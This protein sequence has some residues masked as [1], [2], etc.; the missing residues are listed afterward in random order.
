MSCRIFKGFIG[1]IAPS[2]TRAGKSKAMRA[3]LPNRSQFPGVVFPGAGS[4][5]HCLWEMSNCHKSFLTRII[6]K[7][8]RWNTALSGTALLRNSAKALRD[9]QV[10]LCSS[11]LFKWVPRLQMGWLLILE[12]LHCLPTW[13]DMDLGN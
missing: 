3:A 13:I 12:G 9:A 5:L 8:F 7:A 2:E 11:S 6:T 1:L 4:H 10:Q